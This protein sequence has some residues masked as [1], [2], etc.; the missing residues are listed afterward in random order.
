MT[1]KE[2]GMR[3]LISRMEGYL[4]KKG[5]ELNIEK[6]KITRFRKGG[7]RR[8]KVDWRWKRKEIEEVRKIKYFGYTFTRN[9]GQEAHIRERRKK[10]TIMMREAWRIGKKIWGK[11]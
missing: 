2:Q 11:D 6:T 1:G 4:D 3:S 9:G 10:I 5:L 8:K 7:R